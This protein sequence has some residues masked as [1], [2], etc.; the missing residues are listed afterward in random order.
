MDTNTLLGV[1][2]VATG[3]ADL[4]MA[5]MLAGKLPPAARTGLML[6]GIVFL[7]AGAALALRLVRVV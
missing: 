5:R 7:A 1:L 4:A 2:F 6:F 3:V